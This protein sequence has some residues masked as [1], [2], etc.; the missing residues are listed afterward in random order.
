MDNVDFHIVL[1]N[2]WACEHA[3]APLTHTNESSGSGHL[4]SSLM[5]ISVGVKKRCAHGKG[6]GQSLGPLTQ[7]HEPGQRYPVAQETGG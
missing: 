6:Q 4:M 1:E 3:S 7:V 2:F 5:R